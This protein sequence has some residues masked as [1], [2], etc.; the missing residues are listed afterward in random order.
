MKRSVKILALVMATLMLCLSLAACGKKLSGEYELDATIAGSGVV[1]TYAFKG[2]KVTITL[3]T[4]VLGSV[5]N[6]VE[7]EGKYSIDDD[8]IT[9]EFEDEDDD[10]KKYNGEFDFKETD[11]GIKIGLL[12]YKKVD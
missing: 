2:S 6:T 10:A 9:F 11:D 7:I 12:E 1:T 3:E 8:K 4:K 5:T